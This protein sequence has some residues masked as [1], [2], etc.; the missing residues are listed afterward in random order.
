MSIKEIKENLISA[1]IAGRSVPNPGGSYVAV[2]VRGNIAYVAIQFPRENGQL[3]YAGKLGREITTQDGYQA[4]RIAAMNVVGQVEK[5]V[6]F[7]KIEGLNHADIY[8]CAADDWQEA[9]RSAD[10][11]SDL[12]LEVLGDAG[13][14]TRAIMGVERLSGNSCIAV[15]ASFTLKTYGTHQE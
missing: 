8:Y 2:N 15:V 5:F 9:P 6:G 3:L 7:E 10:G 14:H 4:G 12:F 13:K 1:G 11:V